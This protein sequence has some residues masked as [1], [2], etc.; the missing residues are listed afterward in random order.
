LQQPLFISLG[1]IACQTMQLTSSVK[2]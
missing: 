1:T 2:C